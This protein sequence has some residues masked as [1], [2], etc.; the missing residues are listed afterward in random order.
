MSI[1]YRKKLR[2][3]RKAEG[4]TQ[5]SMALLTGISLSSIRNYESGGVDIGLTVIDRVLAVPV[6]QK[7]ALWLMTNKI[8]P[9]AGQ[10]AP[11]LSH[12][13]QEKTIFPPSKKGIG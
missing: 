12:Y 2:A 1:D 6:F 3:M 5:A 4:M 9:E 13:G 11:D 10:I 7:Y 8:L